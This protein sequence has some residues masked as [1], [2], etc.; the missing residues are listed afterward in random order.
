MYD[1]QIPYVKI[2]GGYQSDKNFTMGEETGNVQA[3]PV[4]KKDYRAIDIEV[5][6]PTQE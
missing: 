1:L 4:G 6:Y 2:I 3:L 5:I